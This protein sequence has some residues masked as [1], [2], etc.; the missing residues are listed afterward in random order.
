MSTAFKLEKSLYEVLNVSP[1]SSSE[2]IR[3]AY[4]K[5]KH[6]YSEDNIALY[7]IMPSDERDEMIKAIEDAY[8]ILGDEGKRF[9]YNREMGF[10]ASPSAASTTSPSFTFSSN[11][12][13]THTETS[14]ENTSIENKNIANLIANNKYHLRFEVNENFEQEIESIESFTG[15]I[16][17]KIREYKNVGL[18][19][20]SDMTRVSKK[21]LDNIEK[22]NFSSLPALVYVRGFVYQYAKCLRLDPNVVASSYINRVRDPQK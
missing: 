6:A 8:N 3:D 11:S 21:H 15:E 14:T 18:D 7:S 1:E 10:R 20:M 17:K 16:L 2:E 4:L 22:E 13:V 9:Q 19:R 12:E 5:A